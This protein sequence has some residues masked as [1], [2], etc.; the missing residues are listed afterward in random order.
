MNHVAKMGG[1][2]KVV[3]EKFEFVQDFVKNSSKLIGFLI[4]PK[5]THDLPH[6][7]WSS[8]LISHGDFH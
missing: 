1:L 7:Q 8:F 4:S 6:I 5:H 3:D 2:V